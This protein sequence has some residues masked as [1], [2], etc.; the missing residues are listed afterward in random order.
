ML[1]IIFVNYSVIL[2][3]EDKKMEETAIKVAESKFSKEDVFDWVYKNIR[4]IKEK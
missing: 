1:D 2:H 4:R 3:V